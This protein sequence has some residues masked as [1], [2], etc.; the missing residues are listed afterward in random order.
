M[1]SGSNEIAMGRL[2]R[3]KHISPTFRGLTLLRRNDPLPPQ[4]TAHNRLPKYFQTTPDYANLLL[5]FTFTYFL[6][7]KVDKVLFR[8]EKNS[9]GSQLN[10]KKVKLTVIC[11]RSHENSK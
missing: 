7:L 1:Y 9:Q 10:F 2:E 5:N 4:K 11:L 6:D 3:F 8:T